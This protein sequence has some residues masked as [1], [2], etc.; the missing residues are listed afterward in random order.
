MLVMSIGGWSAGVFGSYK[1]DDSWAV[2]AHFKVTLCSL[3]T[4]SVPVSLS[5]YSSSTVTLFPLLIGSYGERQRKQCL[6]PY[7]I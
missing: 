2:C 6:I 4:Q 1:R 7:Y 5:V 3:H